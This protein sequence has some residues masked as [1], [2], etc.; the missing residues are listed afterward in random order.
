MG[1]VSAPRP[2]RPKQFTHVGIAPGQVEARFAGGTSTVALRLDELGEVDISQL[3]PVR[4]IPSYRDK[5]S[6]PRQPYMHHLG[7]H[8]ETESGLERD[9]ALKLDRDLSVDVVLPQALGIPITDVPGRRT[10]ILDF[11][12]RSDT[13]VQLW[14]VRP[15]DHFRDIDAH[16]FTQIKDLFAS[17]SWTLHLFT[18][19]DPQRSTFE[20]LLDA[21]RRMPSSAEALAPGMMAAAQQRTATIDSL[22]ELADKPRPVVVG[23]LWFLVAWGYLVVDSAGGITGSSVVAPGAHSWS[24]DRHRLIWNEICEEAG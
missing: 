6:I 9:L 1:S 5:W 12:V 21:S 13:G 11:L 4:E 24:P 20:H 15:A 7:E 14:M 3:A 10:H 19:H 8:I 22:V 17:I 18:G 16:V 23:V 2:R